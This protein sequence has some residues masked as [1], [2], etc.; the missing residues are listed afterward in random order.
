MSTST[1]VVLDNIRSA[2][3]VGAIFRTCDGAGI[4]GLYLCGI[5]PTPTHPK[6]R[7]TAIG[8]ENSM[9]WQH[10]DQT[11]AALAELKQEGYTL[12][13]V[14]L[15][16][17][18]HNYAE[19]NFPTKTA[20]IFGHEITGVHPMVLAATDAAIQLPMRGKKNSLNIATTVGILTYHLTNVAH[21]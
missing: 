5:T 1:V 4:D 9:Q 20:L 12:V 2:L 6:V 13:A 15:T 19:Y 16:P 17:Q 11:L 14:E 21:A 8:A 10:F 18:S 7:K 3:N